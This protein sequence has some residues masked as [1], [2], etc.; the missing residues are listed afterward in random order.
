[1]KLSATSVL[2]IP[3]SGAAKVSEGP[4]TT[5]TY[6]PNLAPSLMQ[7]LMSVQRTL[8]VVLTSAP[9]QTEGSPAAAGPASPSLPTANP[10][11]VSP[12]TSL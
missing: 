2:L 6:H 4:V 3:I 9:T 1:M 11:M 5:H 12:C 10:A 7:I 8:M